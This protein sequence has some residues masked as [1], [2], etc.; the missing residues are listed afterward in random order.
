MR[1]PEGMKQLRAMGLRHVPVLVKG[2]EHI[3]ADNIQNVAKFVGIGDLGHTALPAPVL[4]E[5]WIT[6]LRAAQRYVRQL[7]ADQ[8]PERAL[9]ARD[10][11]IRI[12]GHHAFGICEAFLDTAQGDDGHTLESVLREPADGECA[13]GAEIAAYGQQVLDRM[14]AWWG[15][16]VDAATLGREV[17]TYSGR[18]T[19]G[20]LLERSTWHSAQHVRQLV[21]VLE[22]L[23]IEPDGQIAPET[24]SGLPLPTNVW[25]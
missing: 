16:G 24:L 11:S 17:Q 13:T 18:Q 21:A 12:L 6:L 4:V 22:R 20:Q 14:Q 23:G 1:D 7:P 19:V 5:K 10:R 9:A 2:K 8:L 3:F 15:Q 25:E